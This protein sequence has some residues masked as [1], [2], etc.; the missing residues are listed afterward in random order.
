ML[1]HVAYMTV[2]RI[3]SM[4]ISV[5]TAGV[6]SFGFAILC[7]LHNYWQ[8]S[9]RIFL[10]HLCLYGKHMMRTTCNYLLKLLLHTLLSVLFCESLLV[11]VALLIVQVAEQLSLEPTQE[12]VAVGTH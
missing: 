7:Q 4:S 8:L 9:Y 5:D 3:L 10:L 1:L 11:L 12:L 2:A 6:F